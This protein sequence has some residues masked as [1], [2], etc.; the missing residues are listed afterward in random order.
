VAGLFADWTISHLKPETIRDLGSQHAAAAL[1]AIA[2]LAIIYAF[3]E[4][5][6]R[7]YDAIGTFRDRH[8]RR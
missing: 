1:G 4:A 5:A 8:Q 2:G 7:L 3:G 6:M